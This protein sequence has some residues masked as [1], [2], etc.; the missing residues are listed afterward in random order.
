M[1][2]LVVQWTREHKSKEKEPKKRTLIPLE[3]NK[4]V[5]CRAF[6]DGAS[7]GDPPLGGSGGVIHFSDNIRCKQG[8]LLVIVPITRKN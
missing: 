3:I 4:T 7:Q 6:F 5:P 1:T 8:F 2:T